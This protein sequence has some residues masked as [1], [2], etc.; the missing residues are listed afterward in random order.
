MSAPPQEPTAERMFDLSAIAPSEPHWW[1]IH[2]ASRILIDGSGITVEYRNSKAK[3]LRWDDPNLGFFLV[4]YRAPV[5]R[6]E[7]WTTPAQAKRTPYSFS[8]GP[9]SAPTLAVPI[10]VTEDAYQA[11][12]DAGFAMRLH[13]SHGGGRE[14]SRDTIVTVFAK[15]RYTLW[16]VT[17]LNPNAE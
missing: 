1:T 11:I 13:V 8:P 16:T 6:N 10:W 4:D 3:Q 9:F 14:Y 17:E 15:K 12:Y 2:F 5:A 7:R